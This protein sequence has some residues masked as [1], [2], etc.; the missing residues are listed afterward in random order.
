MKKTRAR[1]KIS[2]HTA[3]DMRPEYRFDYRNARPNRFAHLMRET[4]VT[5][6]LDPDVATVFQSS[7]SVNSLLRS[8]ISAF[9]RQPRKQA[10][11]A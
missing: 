5:V 3:A 4:T 10:K 1:K 7:A 8:V 9:P 2:R 6:T 11:S